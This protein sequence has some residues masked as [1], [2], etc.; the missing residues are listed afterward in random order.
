MEIDAEFSS[1]VA[2]REDRLL[3]RGQRDSGRLGQAMP[4]TS[5]HAFPV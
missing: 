2:D 4:G 5:R 1:L 3:K